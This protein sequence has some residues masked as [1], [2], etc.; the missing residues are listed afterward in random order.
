MA[1]KYFGNKTN[2]TA[3]KQGKKVTGNNKQVH[4][5]GIGVKKSGRG[6]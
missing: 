6:K 3:D 2:N 5:K 1:S 4:N